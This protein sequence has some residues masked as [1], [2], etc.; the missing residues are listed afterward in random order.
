V[1]GRCRIAN[2]WPGKVVT[3]K[4]SRTVKVKGEIL[5]FTT[6]AGADYCLAPVGS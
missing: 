6:E 1:G 4:S 2:P 3:I 5:E